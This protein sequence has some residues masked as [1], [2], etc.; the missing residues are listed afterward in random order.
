MATNDA[1]ANT[2]FAIN[3]V[4][5]IIDTLKKHISKSDNVERKGQIEKYGLYEAREIGNFKSEGINVFEGNDPKRKDV[6]GFT[7]VDVLMY[8]KMIDMDIE[9]SQKMVDMF[10]SRALQGT[11]TKPSENTL[12]F[13]GELGPAPGT[14]PPA[15]QE[16]EGLQE[17]EPELEEPEPAPEAQTEGLEEFITDP[18]DQEK[19]LE[20]LKRLV[21]EGLQVYKSTPDLNEAS[22]K[23]EDLMIQLD[24]IPPPPGTSRRKV[25]YKE[26]E[27]K[28]GEY[29]SAVEKAKEIQRL[30]QL[31]GGGKKKRTHNK[32]KR[33]SK[34]KSTPVKKKK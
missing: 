15:P 4:E 20:E 8:Y 11:P 9:G 26:Y 7:I 17:Q 33:R 31:G 12:E 5:K 2:Q 14:P 30:N 24:P 10:D 13:L 29:I 22:E 21:R 16:Q 27:E 32:K 28:K 23:I 19:K 18:A 3:I 34:K 6:G 25:R 1:N